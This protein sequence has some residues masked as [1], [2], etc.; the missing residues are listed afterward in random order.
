MA[1]KYRNAAEKV[2]LIAD[3]WESLAPDATFGGMTLAQFRNRV[4]PSLDLREELATID[5]QRIAKVEERDDAD[6]V[7]LDA[8]QLV[9]N[10]VKGDPAYG[11]DHPLLQSM[12]YVR[13]SARWSGLTRRSNGNGVRTEEE[14]AASPAA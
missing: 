14:P 1:T 11:P 12:G 13:K 8:A 7:S 2:G 6:R 9:I 10:S 3:A 4:K 5:S